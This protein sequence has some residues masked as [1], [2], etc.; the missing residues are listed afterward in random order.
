MIDRDSRSKPIAFQA[1]EDFARARRNAF[2]EA[3]ASFLTR[4]PNELLSFE[5]VRQHIP[6]KGQVYRGVQTI[7]I[8]KVAGSVDRYD[9]FNRH[10]LPRQTN[11]QPRWENVDRA[12]LAGISLPPIQVYKIGDVYFVKDGNH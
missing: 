3:V 10:F 4:R 9:D 5:Q 8:A 6:I 7:P 12:A 2:L 11:T 1:Q